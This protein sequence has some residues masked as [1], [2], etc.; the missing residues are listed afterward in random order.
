[1]DDLDN[2]LDFGEE[3]ARRNREAFDAAFRDR[4][5]CRHR[6]V[7]DPS[8]IRDVLFV[9]AQLPERDQ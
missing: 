9:L 6:L 3:R 5:G 4:K 2:I 8:V 7:R 1:M